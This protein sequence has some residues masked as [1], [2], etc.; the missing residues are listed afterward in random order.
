[1]FFFVKYILFLIETDDF[2]LDLLL[3]YLGLFFFIP[4]Y[5]SFSFKGFL[6]ENFRYLID[7]ANI[8]SLALTNILGI[9]YIFN[10][11]RSDILLFILFIASIRGYV[12]FI[13]FGYH[14]IKRNK[15]IIVI[16]G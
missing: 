9:L 6:L 7:L 2:S 10:I 15:T 11:A 3:R 8:I 12:S 1:L 5:L 13:S 16:F 4:K 14:I